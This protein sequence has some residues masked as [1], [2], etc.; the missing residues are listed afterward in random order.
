MEGG[1]RD[2][3]GLDVP[4]N[5]EK[6]PEA[7]MFGA[8]PA[9]GFYARHAEGI[10]LSNVQLR[11]NEEDL[12]PAIVMDDVKDFTLDGFRTDTVAGAS[13]VVWLNNVADAF[14][15]GCRTPAANLFL[16]VSGAGSKGIVLAGNDL[17]RAAR[18][19]EITDAPKSAVQETGNAAAPVG[20]ED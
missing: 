1:N 13:P 4:E 2:S 9:F 20:K 16:R 6:Y 18:R 3:K 14:V 10:T 5:I 12:R 15:R 7:T 8:L 19:L 11:W 17:T